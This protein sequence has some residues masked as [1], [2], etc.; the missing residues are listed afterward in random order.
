[1]TIAIVNDSILYFENQTPNV[2]NYIQNDATGTISNKDAIGVWIDAHFNGMRYSRYTH[3]GQAYL[4][5]E[6]QTFHIGIGSASIIDSLII[7]WPSGIVDKYFDILPNRKIFV[8]E[9]CNSSGT[10]SLNDIPIVTNRYYHQTIHSHGTVRDSI[11]FRVSDFA[12]LLPTFEVE[13][14]ATFL[15]DINGCHL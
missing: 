6:S 13:P 8:T 4:A 3:S 7:S 12:V 15:I 9:D 11:E 2:G 5:Q 1:M 10:I 14:M